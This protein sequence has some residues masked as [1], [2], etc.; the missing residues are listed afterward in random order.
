M[1]RIKFKRGRDITPI[2]DEQIKYVLDEYEQ[3]EKKIE[4]IIA[5][6]TNVK[7]LTFK[8]FIT[9][10]GGETRDRYLR[11]IKLK[12]ALRISTHGNNHNSSNSNNNRNG[13]R[14]SV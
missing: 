11:L 5:E 2:T 8:R 13:T 1:R 10:K 4:Q 14:Q 9:K 6:Q 12:M 7:Y 3:S